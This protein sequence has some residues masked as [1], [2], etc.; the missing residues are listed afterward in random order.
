M[1]VYNGEY[2][3]SYSTKG[4]TLDGKELKGYMPVT[5]S[6]K[7]GCKIPSNDAKV[8]DIQFNS[9]DL[10]IAPYQ[11]KQ[12]NIKFKLVISKWVENEVK[13]DAK[14]SQSESCPVEQETTSVVIDYD[15]LPF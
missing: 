15:D 1:R 8:L 4:R 7:N 6:A 13:T 12:G 9:D 2:G 11:D 14:P 5:F 10:W 3:W